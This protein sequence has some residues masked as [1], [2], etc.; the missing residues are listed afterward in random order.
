M[1][2]AVKVYGEVD[3]QMFSK[4]GRFILGERD[5]MKSLRAGRG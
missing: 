2:Y 4:T 3:V 5:A 1:H